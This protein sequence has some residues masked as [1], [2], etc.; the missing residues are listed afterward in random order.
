MRTQEKSEVSHLMVLAR[1]V[2]VRILQVHFRLAHQGR[3]WNHIVNF[4]PLV[5]KTGRVE[6][7]WTKI[8]IVSIDIIILHIY[9]HNYNWLA[10]RILRQV[11]RWS[12]GRRGKLTS[13][14]PIEISYL[15]RIINE[16]SINK[17]GRKCEILSIRVLELAAAVDFVKIKSLRHGNCKLIN[18]S[19]E[20]MG[21]FNK[22]NRPTRPSL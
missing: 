7:L 19:L 12:L 5:A 10:Q 11:A 16:G 13:R 8:R 9:T 1:L 20:M 17:G 15:R 14:T 4:E 22:A 6:W 2:G 3:W 18:G 21:W